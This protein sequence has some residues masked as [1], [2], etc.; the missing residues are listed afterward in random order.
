MKP[1]LFHLMTF[2]DATKQ[3]AF[4]ET[5][6][7]TKVA[8]HANPDDPSIIEHAEYAWRDN[9]GIMFGSAG[10]KDDDAGPVGTARCYCVVDTDTEVDR[11]FERALAAGA[12]ELQP[13]TD[14]D[15]GG[16]NASVADPEGNQL[17][18]GSDPGA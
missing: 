12:T 5:V 2:R 14:Q 7:F 16:R 10:R 15:Y 8:A 1:Q 17:S 9:G 18:F 13:P 3:M 4:L 6:G 11:V